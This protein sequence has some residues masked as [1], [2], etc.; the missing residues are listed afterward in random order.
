MNH[1]FH[2]AYTHYDGIGLAQLIQKGEVS[3]HEV[4]EA[5]Q[6]H[7]THQNSAINAITWPLHEAARQQLTRPLPTSPLAGVPILIKDL[8]TDITGQPTRNGSRLFHAAPPAVRDHTLIERYRRAGLIFIGKTATPEFGLYPYTESDANGAT[9]NPWNLAHT[10]GGSSGG[11]A[12]AVAAGIVPIAHGSDGGGSLRIPAANCGLFGLKPSRGRAPCGPDLSEQWQGMAIQHCLTRSVRDSAAMLDIMQGID[13]GDVYHCPP[14]ERSFLAQLDLP[15]P[16][17][18]IALNL[19]PPQGGTLDPEC[20]AA[21]EACA[22]LLENLGHHVEEATP[23][24]PSAETLQ[25][26]MMILVAGEMACLIRNLSL[27]FGRPIRHHEIE[28]GSWAL[29]RYGERISAGEFAWNR[30]LMLRMGRY[31]ADFHQHY[32]ILLCPIMNQ[33]PAKIGQFRLARAQEIASRLLIGTLKQDWLLAPSQLIERN[34][35]RML[36]YLG[37]TAPFNMSG[38]PAMSLP[39]GLSASGLPI[40]VQ[41][42]AAYTQDGM[43]LQLAREIEEA[44]PW[45]HCAPSKNAPKKSAFTGPSLPSTPNLHM[46]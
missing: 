16:R 20:R 12:A 7:L 9:R 25:R 10:P 40:G 4:L 21:V 46:R 17:L 5:A 14:P 24:L 37:W 44:Q 13:F 39:F 11:S 33:L 28:A 23:L 3:A 18:R 8:F 26:A 42:V 30:Q 31:M 27:F 19:T 38:Q 36:D 34:A 6:H 1:H 29:S 41:C 2:T 43:L 32:D 22:K 45:P 15:L 35:R